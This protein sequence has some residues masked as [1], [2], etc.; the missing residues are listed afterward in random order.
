M[1]CVSQWCLVLTGFWMYYKDSQ[2]TSLHSDFPQGFQFV[3]FVVLKLICAG[4]L[5]EADLS[6]VKDG[7][8]RLKA[9]QNFPDMMSLPQPYCK[10]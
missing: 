4:W 9:L 2:N 1:Q 3:F 8:L 5:K 7:L 10:T 6:S